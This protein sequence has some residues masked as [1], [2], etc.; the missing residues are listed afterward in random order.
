MVICK[1]AAHGR[2]LLTRGGRYERVDCSCY[3]L[4]FAFIGTI[5]KS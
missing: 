5:M 2:W 4:E 3:L 1:V